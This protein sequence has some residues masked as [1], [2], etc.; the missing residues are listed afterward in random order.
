MDVSFIFLAFGKRLFLEGPVNPEVF[1]H[2]L[3]SVHLLDSLRCLL[4]GGIL[5]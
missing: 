3:L 5:D 1:L 2:D 4:K